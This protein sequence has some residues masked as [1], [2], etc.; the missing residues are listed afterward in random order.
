MRRG[1]FLSLVGGAVAMLPLRT[2]A[3]TPTKVYRVGLLSIGTAMGEK[4]PLGSAIIRD[5]GQAGYTLGQNLAFDARGAE[6]HQE[7]LPQ[8]VAQ[9][10]ASK[11]D[12]LVVNGYPAT[13]A[14]KQGTTLPI[15]SI[16]AGDPVGTGL[17]SSL[18]HP[19]GNLT[20]ISDVSAELTPKRLDLLKQMAPNMRRVA[21]LWNADNLGMTLR[22]RAAETGAL[23]LGVDVQPLG[24]RE[25][26]DFTQA[27]EAM[28][29]EMPDAILMVTDLLT[30]LNRKP[31]FEF[32]AA[33]R[34]PAIYEFAFL[35]RDG[36]LM[37][38]G[39]DEGESFGRVAA[40]VRRILAGAKPSELPFEEPAKFDLAI[41]LKTAK[42]LGL[43]V[44]PLLL[45]NAD[46]V[47]E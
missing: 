32:A 45:A 19:G 17:V 15:V 41:N 10:A 3:Q 16:N 25:P 22:Y 11:V 13:L 23:A 26:D 39:P 2:L 38:Y 31:V 33:H 14:A 9:F 12:V 36:G 35:A 44:P 30:I 27:F 42:T 37:S 1:Q 21:I 46:E 24:V 43:T 4:S 8:L 5:L 28:N 40:L 7:R 20:G 47:I 29:R 34:L 6:G 18:S